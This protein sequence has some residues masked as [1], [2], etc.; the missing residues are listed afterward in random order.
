MERSIVGTWRLLSWE[1]RTATGK[2]SYPPGTDAT[3]LL[4]Y[5]GDGRMWVAL[6]RADRPSFGG[7]DLLGGTT[8][9]RALAAETYVSYCGRYELRDGMV[10]H[11]LEMS[12]F[13]NWVGT[14]QQRFVS[15]DGDQLVLSTA[16]IPLAGDTQT[17]HLTWRRMP[18]A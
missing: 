18:S 11:R 5:T 14:E 4:T 1:N 2:L 6:A 17:A 10:I 3:G 8:E 15:W 16:P 7:P 13:P 12:L 9:E